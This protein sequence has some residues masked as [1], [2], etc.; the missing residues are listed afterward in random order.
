MKSPMD[1]A[2]ARALT[3]TK[4]TRDSV[5]GER[6]VERR[7]KV[8][9][10]QSSEGKRE[11]EEASLSQQDAR[12]ISNSAHDNNMRYAHF[13]LRSSSSRALH[14]PFEVF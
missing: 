13:S 7:R 2:R 5:F 6:I 14:A 9:D 12:A 11:E 3:V 10:G 4:V 1:Y 8:T